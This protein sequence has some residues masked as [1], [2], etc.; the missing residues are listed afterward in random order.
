MSSDDWY[1][2]AYKG[3]GPVE[4]PFPRPLYPPDA[5]EY[6]KRP[7]VDGPDVI[8]YKRALCR[9]GRW[10]DW[11]PDSWDDS[12]SNA[13]AHG[14]G[15][16][17]KD[18]GLAGYQ[19][20]QHLD[21]S[22]WL[23]T[24]T[25]NNLRYS[26]ISDPAAP[27]YGQPLFDSVCVELLNEAWYMFEGSEP[28]PEDEI[29]TVRGAAL[30]RALSQLGVTESPAGSNMNPY[31]AWY[32]M[33]GVPWCAIFVTWAYEHGADDLDEDSPSFIKGQRYSYC[34]Y[35]VSDARNG[36]YGLRTTDDPIPG[37]L[38]VYDWQS[39]TVY[40]HIGLFEAW[41]DPQTFTAIEAN[42]SLDNDSN[43]G[44]VMRRTRN[45]AG[46]GTVFIRVAEP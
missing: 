9:G 28:P 23:G 31:G 24:K 20:Q 42:T 4:A 14:H 19:R 32:G 34:P 6:G 1:Q 25:F 2:H 17:V 8:A 26:L 40:D 29:A 33:N 44:E 7:S 27:H 41:L 11:D 12:Y 45:R 37:D 16:N 22:G 10:G 3:G 35:V 5:A 46:Q 18:T 39:D 36:N 30:T 43:G 13:F 21:A 38:V 15:P